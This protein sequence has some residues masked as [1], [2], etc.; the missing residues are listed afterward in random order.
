MRRHA[1][2]GLVIARQ[3]L[4]EFGVSVTAIMARSRR[5]QIG[6]W[7]QIER[8]V[9]ALQKA[10]Y[11]AG[12][13]FYKPYEQQ[14]NSNARVT[15]GRLPNLGPGKAKHMAVLVYGMTNAALKR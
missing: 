7:N 9:E 14:H 10:R 1:A 8:S 3:P 6:L 2:P 5:K 15:E 13:R 12:E 11:K 4:R